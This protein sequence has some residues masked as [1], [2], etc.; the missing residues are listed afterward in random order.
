MPR[1]NFFV[2]SRT[3]LNFLRDLQVICWNSYY[4]SKLFWLEKLSLE[5]KCFIRF[6]TLFQMRFSRGQTQ[7]WKTFVT[8]WG[9]QFS[10]FFEAFLTLDLQEVNRKLRLPL[11]S[12][13]PILS[14]LLFHVFTYC[15]STGVIINNILTSFWT[16]VMTK[17]K[18]GQILRNILEILKIFDIYYVLS[19]RSFYLIT[20]QR[21]LK[22]LIYLLTI[23]AQKN[24]E[25][26]K[27][28][29]IN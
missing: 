10:R 19:E 25:K 18:V 28:Y 9:W 4:E 14:L 2:K 6:S 17:I 29:L 16:K 13:D 26:T 8:F 21:F 11:S 3:L 23:S 27:N 20:R 5:V 24:A 7:T 12:F 22:F 15:S 1:D